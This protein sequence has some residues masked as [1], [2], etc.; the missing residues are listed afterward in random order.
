[1]LEETKTIQPISQMTVKGR[2]TGKSHGTHDAVLIQIMSKTHTDI[3]IPNSLIHILHGL[4]YLQ[5]SNFTPREIY[6]KAGTTL[7]V[8]LLM[9]SES[10]VIPM[11]RRQHI[12]LCRMKPMESDEIEIETIETPFDPEKLSE[13][14]KRFIEEF[15]F[16]ETTLTLEEHS[17]LEKMDSVRF[18]ATSGMY[19]LDYF[20]QG[21]K[22]RK[23]CI[24]SKIYS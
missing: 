21:E 2:V 15:D 6:L 19:R 22:F 14:D 13:Q 17:S 16:T 23:Y 1:M 3:M 7:G 12:R 11:S 5:V 4:T 10:L 9:R 24:G 18:Y 8:C 20:E